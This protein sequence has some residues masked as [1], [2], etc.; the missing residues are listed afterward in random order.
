[1]PFGVRQLIKEQLP[2]FQTKHF[3]IWGR[4]RYRDALTP[5]IGRITEFCYEMI[6]DNGRFGFLACD[7]PARNCT[8]DECK[9]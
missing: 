7:N 8:D 2:E 1:M 6:P 4:A 3:Y 9:D 5:Q